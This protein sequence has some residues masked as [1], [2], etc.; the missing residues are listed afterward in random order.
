[1]PKKSPM[2]ADHDSIHTWPQNQILF[3]LYGTPKMDGIRSLVPTERPVPVSR[4]FIDIPNDHIRSMLSKPEYAG[5]DGEL[6]V[7]SLSADKVFNSTTSGVMTRRFK[8]DFQWYVFDDFS[9]PD[10]PYTERQEKLRERML[11]LS[12]AALDTGEPLP[13]FSVATELLTSWEEL[14][15]YEDKVLGMGFEGVITRHP[16]APYKFGR[17]TVTDQGMLKLKRFADSEAEIIGFEE[18]MRNTNINV[19]DNFGRAKRS[20]AQAGLV[21]G[22][23][24]GKFQARDL[25]TGVEFLIGMFKGL[26]NGDKQEIWNNQENYLGKIA[27]YQH[28]AHGAIDKPRHSKFIGWRDRRDM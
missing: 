3:P 17:S 24:L 21:P 13:L 5:F 11:R 10:M 7:G 8:P 25:E 2:L 20:K 18:L 6:V 23:T 1:M 14:E 19:G 4:S 27:K 22:G 12:E 9:V 26:T 15:A 28:L 16:T